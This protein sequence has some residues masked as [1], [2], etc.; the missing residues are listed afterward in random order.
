MPTER[1]IENPNLIPTAV[2]LTPSYTYD[3]YDADRLTFATSFLKQ[4]YR[5]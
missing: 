3:T 2:L 4:K 5:P 1:F